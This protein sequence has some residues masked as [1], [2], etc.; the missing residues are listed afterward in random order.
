MSDAFDLAD[1]VG[2]SRAA[3]FQQTL[4][5][6]R[7]RRV[8]RRLAAIVVVGVAYAAGFATPRPPVVVREAPPQAAP[9]VVPAPAE[10]PVT[11]PRELERRASFAK[12]DDERAR[13]LR[14]AGDRYLADSGDIES[15]L[16]C[17]R[18]LIDLPSNNPAT[19]SDAADSWL[20]A[21]LKRGAD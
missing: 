19:G 1:P 7:R 9:V 15:A 17:Y 6:Q 16:R 18:R 4:R 20:L 14:S 11:N 12:F 21:A 10:S 13:F 5:V 3:V 8:V 2:A